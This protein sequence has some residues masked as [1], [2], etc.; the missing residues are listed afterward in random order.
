MALNDLPGYDEC[1]VK[2]AD[3]LKVAGKRKQELVD[4]WVDTMQSLVQKKALTLSTDSA[5]VELTGSSMMRV[6]FDTRLTT[7]IR[8]AKAL[9]SHGV[10]LPKE[11]KNLVEKAGTLT[12]RARA[13]QQVANFHNT[14]GDRMVPS[15]RPLMLTA[16]LALARAVREQSGV[17]WSDPSAVDVYTARLKE[18]AKK[19][20]MQNTELAAKH[21]TLRD[22]VG[23]LLKGE[24]INL[25]S[26]SSIWKDTLSNM[27]NIVD[28][29]ET[30]YG[31]TKAWKLHWDR[32]LLKALGVAY[33]YNEILIIP[34]K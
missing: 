5:V 24:A 3:A 31:N 12:S 16:A 27:R 26:N 11:I 22:L 29:V 25:V 14:I 20:A 6:N 7:L 23:N 9:S 17:V 4:T 15:Q 34:F 30:D 8:E 19:F 32:Q 10:E 1:T 21:V 13:L 28:A 33:R 2:I 18:L